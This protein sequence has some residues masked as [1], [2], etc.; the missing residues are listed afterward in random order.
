MNRN[1]HC[2]I[3]KELCETVYVD[4][5]CFTNHPCLDACRGVANL[6]SRKWEK[7]ISA[8]QKLPRVVLVLESPHKHEY[9]QSTKRAIR[10]A[11]GPTGDSIDNDIINLLIEAYHNQK[12]SKNLPPK[13]LLDV[14]EAVSYQCSNNKDPIKQKERN[15]LFRKVWNEFGKDDFEKRMR[16]LSPFAVIN[17]CTGCAKNIRSYINRRKRVKGNRQNPKYLKALNVLVQ[18]SLDAIWELNPNVDLL[19]SSHPSSSHFKSKGLFFR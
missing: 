7:C 9:N 4:E 1:L 13:V 8:H 15:E 10:P 18:I 6:R 2:I 5:P 3:F 11:N 19:F 14:V 17:A 16:K 12:P